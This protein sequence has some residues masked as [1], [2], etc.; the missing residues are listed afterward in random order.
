MSDYNFM[1]I[2]MIV[3]LFL[4]AFSLSESLPASAHSSSDNIEDY[5][6]DPNTYIVGPGDVF[7][8]R[9][10]TSNKIINTNLTVSPVVDVIVPIVGQIDVSNMDFSDVFE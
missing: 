5:V 8:F 6:I 3:I 7:D 9:M 1:S 2:K 4:F 10:N